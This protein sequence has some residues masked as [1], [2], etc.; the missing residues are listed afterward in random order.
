MKT[1]INIDPRQIES[2]L[3]RRSL[4]SFVLEVDPTMVMTPF[5]EQYYTLLEQFARGKISRLMVSMPPQH[6]KSR[7]ASEL[8]PAYLLGLDPEL[9]IAIGSY[10]FALARLF[11]ARVQQIIDSEPY[12]AIFPHTRLKGGERSTAMRTAEQVDIL[13]HGGGLRLVGREGALTGTRVDVMI[14]DDIYKDAMEAY[15]PTIRQGAWQWYS[16]VVRTRLH[17]HSRELIVF[18]R[19]HEH[20][21]IGE[22]SQREE[23]ITLDNPLG[24]TPHRSWLKVNFEALKSTPPTAIDG[25]PLG[26]ALW[27]ERHSRELLLERQRLDG[28]LFESLYQGNP[29][30]AQGLLYTEWATYR[31]LPSL[32]TLRGNYTDTA[33]TGNDYLCSVSY[34]VDDQGVIYLTDVVYT[35]SPMEYTEVQVAQMIERNKSQIVRVESNNGGRGFARALARLL[36]IGGCRIESF[37]QSCNKAARIL[38]NST[39]VNHRIRMPTDWQ[40]RWSE[41]ASAIVGFGRNIESN[42]H[43]DGPDVLTGIVEVESRESKKIQTLTFIN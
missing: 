10:S 14:L 38:S 2:E 23:V 30:P 1:T 32:I 33:D 3:G 28:P 41:F 9:R 39:T 5:H 37:H 24:H 25:R 36:P 16:S 8:L 20:D 42:A 17:N 34:V 18:T 6:G 4:K 43:D 15:S 19:W 22:L 13:G 29:Q 21:L 26:A 35:L 31:A 12:A 27:P 40:S 11:G 7:G